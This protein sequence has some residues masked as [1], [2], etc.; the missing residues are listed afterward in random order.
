MPFVGVRMPMRLMHRTGLEPH[1]PSRH[2]LRH[3][4]FSGRGEVHYAARCA[5][6]WLLCQE[7]MAMRSRVVQLI[8]GTRL[9]AVQG[10]HFALHDVGLRLR[11][12]GEGPWSNAEC[13][14]EHPIA[15][16]ERAV[17]R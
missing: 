5:H 14:S 13:L 11:N 4:K 1:N 16:A 3:R 6:P 15:D 8:N 17:F 12:L 7:A 10:K 2:S 9:G